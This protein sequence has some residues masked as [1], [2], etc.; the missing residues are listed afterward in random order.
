MVKRSKFKHRLFVKDKC[1]V[2]KEIHNILIPDFS[3]ETLQASTE[4]RAIDRDIKK[5]IILVLYQ[6]RVSILN[7]GVKQKHKS[8][9]KIGTEGDRTGKTSP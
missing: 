4:Q 2:I 9:A 1:Q 8:Q 3:A 5:K 7:D 6:V